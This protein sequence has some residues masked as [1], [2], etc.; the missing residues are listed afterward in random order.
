MD[1]KRSW[2]VWMVGSAYAILGSGIAVA[3]L[4]RGHY[5][6]SRGHYWQR[7][8][9]LGGALAVATGALVHRSRPVLGAGLLMAGAFAIALVAVGLLVI[10]VDPFTVSPGAAITYWLVVTLIAS[11]PAFGT[12]SAL[13]RGRKDPDLTGWR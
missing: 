11:G 10:A 1:T 3:V 9:P 13:I 2:L 12:G 8:I 5:W 4:S 7:S 6:P